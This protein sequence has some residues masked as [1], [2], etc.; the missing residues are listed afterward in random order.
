MKTT[1]EVQKCAQ[2]GSFTTIYECKTK[3]DANAFFNT[4]FL[5]DPQFFGRVNKVVRETVTYSDGSESL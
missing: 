1:Y 3:K 2:D 4:C 5:K